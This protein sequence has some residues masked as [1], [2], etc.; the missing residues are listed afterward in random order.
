[1]DIVML[2]ET[3]RRELPELL[4]AD[5]GFRDY[6]LELMRREHPTRAETQ[7][8][9]GGCYAAYARHSESRRQSIAGS[10]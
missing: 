3:L 9:F 8:R 10:E 1:M 5:P 7:D 2:K 4:R 6:L